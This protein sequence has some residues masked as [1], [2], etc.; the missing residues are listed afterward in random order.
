MFILVFKVNFYCLYTVILHVGRL[1]GESFKRDKSNS[2]YSLLELSHYSL[3]FVLTYNLFM[4]LVTPGC[5]FT[6]Y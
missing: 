6:F 2:M 5:Q 1:V 4:S 3:S